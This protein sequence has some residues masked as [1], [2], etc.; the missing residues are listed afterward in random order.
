VGKIQM[1]LAEI[2][3]SLIDENG[4]IAASSDLRVIGLSVADLS[5]FR[6]IKAGKQWTI[7]DLAVGPMTKKN[8][9]IAHETEIAESRRGMIV[10]IIDPDKMG[11][12][13]QR[14]RDRGAV[15][16]PDLHHV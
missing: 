11:D 7:S 15:L 5:Y 2:R 1:S 10:A 9:A 14:D 3:F 16:G 12:L 13:R 8:F 4:T 6:D